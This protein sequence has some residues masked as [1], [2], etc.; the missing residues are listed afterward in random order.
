ME[1]AND[2]MGESKPACQCAPKSAIL[3]RLAGF[4]IVLC[5][6]MSLSS[7]IV[8][9]LMSFKTYELENRLQMEMNKASIFDPSHR[10]LLNE[11]GTLI[12]Q[13]ATPIGQL[14]DEVHVTYGG[15]E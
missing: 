5:V 13:L 12:P 14:V 11:D 2:S 8:C 10:A 3:Q 9:L 4:P 15:F 7:V 1:T 6:L